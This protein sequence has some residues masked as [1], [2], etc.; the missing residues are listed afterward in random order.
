[1]NE[2]TGENLVEVDDIERQV[3]ARDR[4][5][6]NKFTKDLQITALRGARQLYWR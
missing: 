2:I 1:M 5:M 3:I 4:E 6:D